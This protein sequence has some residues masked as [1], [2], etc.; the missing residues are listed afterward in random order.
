MLLA[1]LLIKML[2]EVAL[3]ALLGRWLLGLLVGVGRE[4][5]MFWRLLHLAVVLLLSGLG[6]L[7]GGRLGPAG[8]ARWA[9]ALLVLL[10]LLATVAKIHFCLVLG[11]GSCR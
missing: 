5:N 6:R 9:A 4:H 10:W 11:P 8:Q 7:S 1:A 2:T 3:L